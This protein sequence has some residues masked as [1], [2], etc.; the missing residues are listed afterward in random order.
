MAGSPF[1]RQ[2]MGLQWTVSCYRVVYGFLLSIASGRDVRGQASLMRSAVL[3]SIQSMLR[4]CWIV[5]KDTTILHLT[6]KCAWKLF[7][8]KSRGSNFSSSHLG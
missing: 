6:R 3:M 5:A 4:S 1:Q 2:Y 8:M 7:S